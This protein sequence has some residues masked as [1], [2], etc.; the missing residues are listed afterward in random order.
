MSCY[1]YHSNHTG[2]QPVSRINVTGRFLVII[3]C[4]LGFSGLAQSQQAETDVIDCEKAEFAYLDG[5]AEEALIYLKRCRQQ[6]PDYLPALTLLGKIQTEYGRYALAADTFQQ[7]LEQGADAELFAREWARSLIGTRQFNTLAR[8]TGFQGFTPVMRA[9]WLKQRA[10]ACRELNEESCARESYSALKMLGEELDAALGFAGLAIEHKAWQEAREQLDLATAIDRNDVRVLL[11]SGRLAL[12]QQQY[13]EALELV[14]KASVLAPR[15][16]LVLRT[17]VDI[18]LAANQRQ[19]A[20]NTLDLIL[21]LSPEDPFAMLVHNSL[22]PNDKY[23]AILATYKARIE[24]LNKTAKTNDHTLYYLEGLIAY[25]SGSYEQ[26]LK[27]FTFLVKEKAFFPQTLTLLAKTHVALKQPGQAISLLEP[28]Q[29]T[30]LA[31]APDSMAL[32]IELFIEDGKVF[33]ALPSWRSFA[34][35]YPQR[36]ETGLLEVKILFGRGMHERAMQRLEQLRQTFPESES[37]ARVSAVALSFA[38]DYPQALNIVERQLQTSAQAQLWYNFKGTL[39]L[40]LNDAANARVSFENALRLDNKMV[41]AQANLAWLDFYQGQQDTA[42]A[43]VEQL[44]AQYPA[45][46]PLQQMYAGMLL[47]SGQ[48]EL[49]KKRY[50]MIYQQDSAERTVIESLIAIYQ[51]EGNTAGSIS[52]LTRLIELEHDTVRNLLRRAQ[53]YVSQDQLNRA[54]LDLYKA[55]PLSNGNAT[56]LLGIAN[57]SIQS[58]NHRLAVKSLQQ[59]GQINP[60]DPLPPIKLAELYL[61]QNQTQEAGQVLK[62]A[63]GFTEVA[64]LWLLKGRLAEQQGEGLKA[65]EH[66]HHALR[67]NPAFELAYGKLYGLTRFGIGRAEFEKALKKRVAEAP[68]VVFSRSLLGQYYYYEQ[69]FKEAVPHYER[70]Y[71]TAAD[72]T[73]KAGYARRL[74]QLYF[75]FAPQ[76]AIEYV[77]KAEAINPDDPFILALK[78][79]GEVQMNRKESGLKLLREA[80]TRNGQD[81][82][83][84]YFLVYTLKSLGLHEEARKF[85]TPLLTNRSSSY[86]QEIQQLQQQLMREPQ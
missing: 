14:D 84:Q 78:G 53:L 13:D 63:A 24:Q 60:A 23:S 72:E 62:A 56:L 69:R 76:Q 8:F 32:L 50:E 37:V 35:R 67:L 48:A 34:E 70:L 40:M 17:L 64:E 49:A 6:L 2:K 16:P 74:G 80:Y 61:N 11:T 58:G 27:A 77:A 30:L 20:A 47:S 5:N 82:D 25:Q 9:D 71:L 31:E 39:H 83:T 41:P 33:K 3:I 44:A 59:A 54:D 7:A 57:I 1:W 18:Y 81:A 55:L 68:E 51:Q 42:L 36:L 45:Q 73:T 38:G 21:S 52:M 26:A 12:Y 28:Q 10:L 43:R 19:E 22:E 29:E 15:D 66:Y 46:L 86:S 79:W 4:W 65:S 85:L 75:H